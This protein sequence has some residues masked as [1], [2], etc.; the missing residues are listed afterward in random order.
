MEDLDDVLE[1][2]TI[3]HDAIGDMITAIVSST[4]LE[5]L[6]SVRDA[7][8]LYLRSYDR[9]L[10]RMESQRADFISDLTEGQDND[11]N[12]EDEDDEE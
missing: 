8:D 7:L 5:L 4:G 3:L 1:D 6:G 10:R 12:D 9:V 2:Y 11:D